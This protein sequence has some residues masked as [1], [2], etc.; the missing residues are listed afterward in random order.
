MVRDGIAETVAMS[1][2]GH[3]TRSIFDWYN[4]VSDYLKQ[5]AMKTHQAR[6]RRQL[7]HTQLAKNQFGQSF[8]RNGEKDSTNRKSLQPIPTARVLPN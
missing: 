1:I 3:R 7:A 5:A 4:I 2:S 8:G 6:Q